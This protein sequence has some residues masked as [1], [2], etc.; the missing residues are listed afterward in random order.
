LDRA[1]KG[2]PP[3]AWISDQTF[4]ADLPLL[5]E[6]SRQADYTEA[7]RKGSLCRQLGINV[8][9]L[10]GEGYISHQPDSQTLLAAL[11]KALQGDIEAL[12]DNHPW[13]LYSPLSAF[14]G[15]F[16]GQDLEIIADIQSAAGYS[17]LRA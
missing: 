15:P 8:T 6:Q 13:R 1:S 10:W 9:A 7:A 2:C 14:H 12:L 4:P 17:F 5:V 11:R 16:H 3:E